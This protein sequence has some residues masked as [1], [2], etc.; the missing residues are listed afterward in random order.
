MQWAQAT[1]R[2]IRRLRLERELSQEALAAEA[3]IAMRH[4]GRIERGQANP[5]L[6]VLEKIAGVLGVSPLELVTFGTA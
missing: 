1:G 6:D 4:L 5:T 2:N 3:G